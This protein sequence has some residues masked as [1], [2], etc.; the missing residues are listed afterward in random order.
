MLAAIAHRP[1][2]R[3]RWPLALAL[4]LLLIAAIP[5][6][7]RAQIGG[8]QTDGPQLLGVSVADTLPVG[9]ERTVSASFGH[10]GGLDPLYQAHLMLARADG[11]AG[12][13]V[14]YERTTNTLGL[15]TDNGQYITAGAPGSDGLASS[16][17]CALHA[18]RTRAIERNGVLTVDFALTVQS[19]LEGVAQVFETAVDRDGRASADRATGDRTHRPRPAPTIDGQ[20]RS[21]CRQRQSTEPADRHLR[22]SEQLADADRNVPRRCGHGRRRRLLR[23]LRP[24]HEPAPAPHGG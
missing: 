4:A 6:S 18:E 13:A 10:P 11:A 15:R 5:S 23:A 8:A 16:S 9:E 14:F 1:T 3:P 24:V 20:R 17:W 22:R 7:A 12:C 21:R 2:R 19:R